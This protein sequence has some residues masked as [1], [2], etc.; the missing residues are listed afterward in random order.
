MMR[1]LRTYFT[2]YLF[3]FLLF[4]IILSSEAQFV[5][6]NLVGYI[7]D[8]LLSIFPKSLIY[9]VPVAFLM[10]Y[11]G[12][13]DFQKSKLSQLMQIVLLLLIGAVVTVLE[14]LLEFYLGTWGNKE[15]FEIFLTS[16]FFSTWLGLNIYS[17]IYGAV[18]VSISNIRRNVRLQEQLQSVSIHAIKSQLEH[19]F[20]FNNLNTLY[21]LID[22]S[23]QKA[24]EFLHS[25]SELYR[26]LLKNADNQTVSL[27]D[28]LS[29]VEKFIKMSKERF[30]SNLIV[31]INYSQ[32][33]DERALVPPLS[34]YNL[35]E[36]VIKHNI[37]DNNHCVI[38]TVD[39]TSQFVVVSNNM[40][41]KRESL[42]NENS[43]I[44]LNS[45]RK[46]YSMLSGKEVHVDIANDSFIV[47][48][49]I[50][51]SYPSGGKFKFRG[52]E[53]SSR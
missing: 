26:Y 19:H 34:I 46:I 38:C 15:S 32:E 21:S 9:S 47:K 18:T 10:W 20:L 35:V 50:L 28:E 36:N 40:F 25:L 6:N 33:I 31:S 16:R 39:V 37:I 5:P 49:P 22:D 29:I 7:G 4:A 1:F 30:G 11:C 17:I 3:A 53:N 51:L 43:G 45:L 27:V 8:L 14:K 42:K 52:Y 2:A 23:N 44:G 13:F 41:S 48:I 24:L 12:Q